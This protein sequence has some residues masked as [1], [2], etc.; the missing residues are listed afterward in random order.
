M[1]KWKERLIMCATRRK[2]AKTKWTRCGGERG[3]GVVAQGC[4]RYV[5]RSRLARQN[6]GGVSIRGLAPSNR[7]VERLALESYQSLLRKEALVSDLR[8][9]PESFDIALRNDARDVISPGAVVGGGASIVGDFAFVGNGES[10]RAVLA[11]H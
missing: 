3:G 8:I 5:R 1:A 7:A 2:N 10:V 6:F 11:W 9:N 4:R